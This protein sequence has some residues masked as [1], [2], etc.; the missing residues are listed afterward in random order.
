MVSVP[1]HVEERIFHKVFP[2]I[3]LVLLQASQLFRPRA[4][5]RLH[6]PTPASAREAFTLMVCV[7][8]DQGVEM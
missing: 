3:A 8:G 4:A 6:D 1:I 2:Q 5:L 7:L